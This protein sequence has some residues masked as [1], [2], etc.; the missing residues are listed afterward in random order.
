MAT[1]AVIAPGAMG[2][3]VGARLAGH[4]ARVLTSLTGAAPRAA[5]G[6][7]PPAWPMPRMPTSSPPT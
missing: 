1:I 5:P 7:R 4:G 6:P 2:S 3:A